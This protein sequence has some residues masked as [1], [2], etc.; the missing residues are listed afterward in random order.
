MIRKQSERGL[1]TKVIGLPLLIAVLLAS[2]CGNNRR[3]DSNTWL[4]SDARER[5]RMSEDLVNSRILIGKTI[6]EARQVLGEP[7]F[8]YPSAFQYKIDLGWLFKDPSHYGLQVHLDE[9]RL[10][11]EVKIVD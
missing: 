8:T 3:F 9:R 7:D 2:G 10:V 6:E 4:K 5:G 1:V 11:R